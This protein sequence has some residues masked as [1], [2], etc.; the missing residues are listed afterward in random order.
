LD[1][2]KPEQS[3]FLPT[4]NTDPKILPF[5]EGFP[6]HILMAEDLL[7]NGH[8]LSQMHWRDFEKLIAELL[9]FNGWNVTLLNE[10]KDGSIDVFAELNDNLLGPIKAIWQAKKYSPENKVQLHQLRELSGTLQNSKATKAIMVTTSSFTKGALNWVQNDKYRLEAKDG[11]YVEK[12]LRTK[13]Y[14]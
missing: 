7:R 9:E 6:N 14:H 5:V 12:W 11:K 3:K 1:L 4:G 2:P 13:L 10:T 8:L